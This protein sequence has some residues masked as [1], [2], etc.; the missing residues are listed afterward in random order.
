MTK[1]I[2]GSQTDDS[3]S[4]VSLD[5]DGGSALE[6]RGGSLHDRAKQDVRI[7]DRRSERSGSVAEAGPASSTT[8]L[9]PDESSRRSIAI[10]VFLV[11]SLGAVATV[12]VLI[13]RFANPLW[14]P[15]VLVGSVVVLYLLAS[16][17]L[18]KERVEGLSGFAATLKD[19]MGYVIGKPKSPGK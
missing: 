6:I 16:A 15:V 1:V 3:S 10:G 2:L 4:T 13:T 7:R 17:I 11:L 19:F 14:V 18:P 12:F 5:T 9:P 8:P